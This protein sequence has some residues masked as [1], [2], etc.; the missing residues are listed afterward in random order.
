MVSDEINPAA[1][2]LAEIFFKKDIFLVFKM[3]AVL[4][5]AI[6]VLTPFIPIPDQ[7]VIGT[8]IWFIWVFTLAF[9]PFNPKKTKETIPWYDWILMIAATLVC[10]DY[11]VNYYSLTTKMGMYGT[12][13]YIEIIAAF[14]SCQ[15]FFS[16]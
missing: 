7:I 16:A 11:I 6:F 9:K 13:E 8:F 2:N 3:L 10:A 4:F 15:Q 5:P 1:V 14:I 12:K